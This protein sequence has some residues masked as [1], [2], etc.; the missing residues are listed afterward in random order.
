MAI[1]PYTLQTAKLSFLALALDRA[2]A[3]ALLAQAAHH[4]GK[5]GDWLDELEEQARDIL[6]GAHSEGLDMDIEAEAIKLALSSL[7]EVYESVRLK[8]EKAG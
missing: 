1:D 5:A 2:L 4:G 7:S 8:L 6:K 3:R